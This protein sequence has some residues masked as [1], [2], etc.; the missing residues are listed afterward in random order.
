MNTAHPV[1]TGQISAV[2]PAN[3]TT[4]ERFKLLPPTV[5]G[6]LACV[7]LVTVVLFIANEWA[8]RSGRAAMLELQAADAISSTT[9]EL[10]AVLLDAET[11]QRG[12]LLT[13][14][15]VYLAPYREA[16]ARL[17]V[18]FRRLSDIAATDSELRALV[19]ALDTPAKA[20]LDELRET[21]RLA[22][23][24][25]RG[26]A[27]RI[28]R[29][30]E[31][32]RLMSSLRAQLVRLDQVASE[33]GD[34]AMGARSRQ[35]MIGRVA[36]IIVMLATA[37]LIFVALS[38]VAVE[39]RRRFDEREAS[40]RRAREL[41][42]LVAARTAELATLSTTLQ[43]SAEAERSALA[44]E[45]HD[46]LGGLITAAK[47]DMAFLS[48]KIGDSLDAAGEEKF[49]S[50]TQLLNQA[51]TMKRRVV[52]N[53][54]PSLLDH[55]GLAVALRS[56]YEE[57]CAGVG[58]DFIGTLPEDSL[59]LE[60]SVQL[61]LF[62]VAQETLA[63]IIARGDARHVELVIEPEG[64]GY[65]M[66]VGDDGSPATLLSPGMRHRVESARGQVSL[67]SVDGR[68]NR[69]RT[70]VPRSPAKSG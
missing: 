22:Q 23:A 19:A 37:A 62:R 38:M 31:G 53:L 50:V 1:Q 45:L 20:K 58:L 39:S 60:H 49:R 25:R 61:T 43:M 65:T 41:E 24:D 70:Y 59:E 54:R 28:V 15:P 68:G 55:F 12:F 36:A 30:G 56:H 46:E 32:E 64:E 48:G 4:W 8:Y 63:G 5:V 14:Q 34:S 47:M 33:R 27:L 42:A 2:H 69:L 57:A 44:R 16:E 52:E 9:R 26:D 11:G 6:P 13:G 35:A 66:L 7:L 10:R 17:P 21:M 51:M 40:K 3:P 29:N 67:E 18:L